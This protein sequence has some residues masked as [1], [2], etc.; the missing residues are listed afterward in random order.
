MPLVKPSSALARA[1]LLAAGL[2]LAGCA[3]PP[4]LPPLEPLLDD[5][6]FAPPAEPVDAEQAFA[7][8]PAMRE[9]LDETLAAQVQRRGARDA[10]V[11]A[12]Y[13]RRQ[14]RIDY[15]AAN[16]RTA[17]QAFDARAG[18]CLSLLVMTAALA[19]HLGLPVEFNDVVTEENWSRA[20]DLMV[21]AGHVNITLGQRLV[22]D[23]AGRGGGRSIV[24]DFD[25]PAGG[26][27]PFVRPIG[28]RTVAAMFMNNRAA[29]SLVAGQVDQAYWWV[30]GALREAPTFSP[31]YNTLA[32][33]YQRHGRP[34]RA[35]RVLRHL[36]EREPANAALLSN[37]RNALLQ[38][39]RADE[40]AQVAQRLAA[41]EPVPPYHWY[42][43]GVQALQR[44]DYAAARDAFTREVQRSSFVSEFHYGLALAYLGLGDLK[45]TQRELD[46]AVQNSTTLRERDLY[47]AKLERLEKARATRLQ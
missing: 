45:R 25:P 17:A 22:D 46:L 8:S 26:V 4:P 35:E 15:D 40:A 10:L 1:L 42:Q 21:S 31:A 16:T 6:A 37:L 5:A 43:Q 33:V 38:Q 2:V 3:T 36:L 18:N 32:V 34:E 19:R 39:G 29:E 11:E 23:R 20:G 7:L 13:S 47:A 9:Y 28:E 30:R 14:L 12:L 44:R 27:R 24:I 41:I